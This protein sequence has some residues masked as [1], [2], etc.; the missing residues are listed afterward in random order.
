MISKRPGTV[1]V[2]TPASWA[3]RTTF[4]TTEPRARGMAMISSRIP[5]AWMMSGRSA[6][7]PST[8]R[9]CSS[10]SRC[11]GA[12]DQGRAIVRALESG[13]C[14]SRDQFGGG[15]GQ[16]YRRQRCQRVEGQHGERYARR[17]EAGVGENDR[18][19][20]QA[21]ETADRGDAEDP[22][23]IPGAGLGP[24]PVVESGR[25]QQEQLEGNGDGGINKQ[26]RR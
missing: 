26:G 8:G 24:E 19:E 13:G 22:D 2:C 9:P 14:A 1:R 23:E 11:A 10:G 5:R 18:A 25:E 12:D 3:T 21:K 16:A 15:A 20:H 7:D 6:R 4:R 17:G